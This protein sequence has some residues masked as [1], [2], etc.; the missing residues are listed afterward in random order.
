MELKI[1]L[2]NGVRPVTVF[3]STDF[4]D[5]KSGS[6]LIRRCMKQGAEI[7]NCEYDAFRKIAYG[8]RCAG[9]VAVVPQ[10]GHKLPRMPLSQNPLLIVAQSIE[11]PGNL[12][13]IIRSADAAGADAV[14]VCDRCTDI[15]NP[16]VVR[17]GIGTL[18]SVPVIETSSE[19]AI[20]WFRKHGV[21]IVAA[22]PRA[23]TLYTDADLRC[24][25]AL[26]VGEEHGGLDKKWTGKADLEVR[27]PMRGSADSL[28]VSAAATILLYEAVRQREW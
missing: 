27:I 15:C 5:G 4:D 14:V 8:N 16:N 22:T 26:V 25:V 24:G 2:D 21:R 13:T 23:G 9:V 28:N 19:E 3:H 1:A 11:K 7:F 12:G 17:S 18:F 20:A 6:A 10:P